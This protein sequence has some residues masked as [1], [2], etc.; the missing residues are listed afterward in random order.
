MST[1]AYKAVMKYG[2]A[3]VTNYFSDLETAV[4][5]TVE[6]TAVL[7]AVNKIKGRRKDSKEEIIRYLRDIENT[8]PD[9]V[10]TVR[11]GDKEDDRY[12]EVSRIAI[13]NGEDEVC[14]CEDIENVIADKSR[15]TVD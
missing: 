10:W 6:Y 15:E 3:I 8:D 7:D 4:D 5:Q 13:H 2:I 11:L 9:A 14:A 12:V 1:F